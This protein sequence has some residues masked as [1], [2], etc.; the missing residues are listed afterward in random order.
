MLVPPEQWG[1]VRSRIVARVPNYKDPPELVAELGDD[2]GLSAARAHHRQAMEGF[3]VLRERLERFQPDV[4]VMFGDDQAENFHP[5]NLPTF[6]IYVGAELE[7]YPFHR[8]LASINLWNGAPE[9]RFLFRGAPDF[10]RHMRDALILDGFDLASADRLA[11]WKWG[12]PHAH[13]NALLFLD[14]DGKIPLVPF[15]VNCYGEDGGPG[16]S[17]RPTPRRCYELGSAIRRFLNSRA[18]RVAV[19]ASSS[20]SHSFL[21]QKFWRCAFDQEFDRRNLER[22]REG[23]GSQLADLTPKEIQESGDH[24]FLNWIVALG[25]LGDRPAEI[26]AAQ[27]SYVSTAF[28]VWAVWE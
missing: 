22:I 7:G 8:Q 5:D 10:A 20:W 15:F 21:T 19:V 18:E 11:G 1:A 9:Q 23:K 27:A 14:P 4:L 2:N 26:V 6:S 3:R 17:P 12:L 13:I 24:E 28:R 16:F 25:V